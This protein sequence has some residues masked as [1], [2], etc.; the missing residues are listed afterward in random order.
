MC[1]RER[2]SWSR[3]RR[4]EHTDDEL[5]DAELFHGVG[6]CRFLLGLTERVSVRA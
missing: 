6:W 4:R 2:S 1:Q 5:F 3:E